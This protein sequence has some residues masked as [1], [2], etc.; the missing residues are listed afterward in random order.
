MKQG[1]SPLSYLSFIDPS[2]RVR[3]IV[4]HA[5]H[6]S[7]VSQ[8]KPDGRDP[9]RWTGGGRPKLHA[10]C[11][12]PAE[13]WGLCVRQESA[14]RP[15]GGWS[16]GCRVCLPLW[17]SEGRGR[18]AFLLQPAAHAA[19][20]SGHFS[21]LFCGFLTSCIMGS[22]GPFRTPRSGCQLQRPAVLRSYDMALAGGGSCSPLS[23][24][25][26]LETARVS[27]TCSLWRRI[28]C[29][30]FP[31]PPTDFEPTTLT[32]HQSAPRHALHPRRVWWRRH[33]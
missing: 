1:G 3:G 27:C 29:F 10:T 33:S 6:A 21:A 12:A 25:S 17:A 20:L 8:A 2:Y 26:S 15:E 23:P 7:H 28:N 18:A 14:R 11:Q 9:A 32:I 13:N 22:C 16:R 30:K 31:R 4:S 24:G 5:S 19:L